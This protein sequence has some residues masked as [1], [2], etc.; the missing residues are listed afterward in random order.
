MI[1]KYFTTLSSR[2]SEWTGGHYAF[3]AAFFLVGLWAL[4]GPPTGY[5][6]GWM[7]VINTGT[8]I[9]TFL[10]VFIIQGSQNRDTRAIQVKLDELI[11]ATKGASNRLIDLEQLTPSEIATLQQQYLKLA[12]KARGLGLEFDISTPSVEPPPATAA[13]SAISTAGLA[14]SAS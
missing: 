14:N 12:E 1:E 9:V 7:L 8:T 10:M 13:T 5:S 3:F 11:R 2:I 4:Y 6:D